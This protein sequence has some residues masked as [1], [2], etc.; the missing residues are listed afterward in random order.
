MLLLNRQPID[1]FMF[2]GGEIQV[3]L[4]PHIDTEAVILTWKPTNAAEIT[5]LALT[6]NALKNAGI[7]DIDLDVLYLPYA[8]QDR[9]CSPGEANSLAFI[10]KFLEYFLNLR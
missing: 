6:V 5:F 9:V 3:K 10:C 2:S 1:Y 7:W 4:P 8:R